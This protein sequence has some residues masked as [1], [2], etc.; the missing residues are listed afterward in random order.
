MSKHNK[1]SDCWGST[2]NKKCPKKWK[3]S[4]IFSPASHQHFIKIN[5]KFQSFEF[6]KNMKIWPPPLF[7]QSKQYLGLRWSAW[8]GFE[9]W[10]KFLST[11]STWDKVKYGL[12][13][14]WVGE[15][16]GVFFSLRKAYIL[17]LSLLLLSI[18]LDKAAHLWTF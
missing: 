16:R 17:S 3:K 14:G 11:P 2:L 7:E 4:I 18:I 5:A 6:G 10:L 9:L 12:F 13:L 1:Q 8:E 15:G